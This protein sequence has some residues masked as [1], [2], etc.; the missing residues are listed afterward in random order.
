MILN[1]LYNFYKKYQLNVTLNIYIVI[2]LNCGCKFLERTHHGL[3]VQ[4]VLAGVRLRG[5]WRRGHRRAAV[6]VRRG[7]G[8]RRATGPTTDPAH[9][10]LVHHGV[11][12]GKKYG[13]HN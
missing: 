10:V 8:A 5:M 3:A 12:W 9:T 11:A 2:C 6:H 13:K 1:V 7:G 4:L